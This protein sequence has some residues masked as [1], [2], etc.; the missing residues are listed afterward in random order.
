[1]TNESSLP[2]NFGL[3]DQLG[4]D[5]E[6]AVRGLQALRVVLDID[7]PEWEPAVHQET[8][9]AIDRAL[10]EIARLRVV[11]DAAHEWS[12]D[13]AV[14]DWGDADLL[15]ALWT[16]EGDNTEPC[17]ECD[18]ECGEPCAPCTVVAAHASIDRALDDLVKRGEL[19]LSEPLEI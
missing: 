5:S 1:M 14:R 10:I 4:A 6:R 7:S 13:R 19:Y 3:N 9:R 11:V 16:F 12:G 15:K 17:P 18:G 2:T 8:R